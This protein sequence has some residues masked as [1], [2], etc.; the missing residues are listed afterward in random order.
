MHVQFQNVA[1][2]KSALLKGKKTRGKPVKFTPRLAW[3]VSFFLFIPFTFSFSSSFLFDLSQLQTR[4]DL[5]E[6]HL[7][8]SPFRGLTFRFL[9]FFP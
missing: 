3:L 6:L 8:P 7:K 4:G 9:S 2:V 1:S 5:D